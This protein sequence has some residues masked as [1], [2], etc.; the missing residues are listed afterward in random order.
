MNRS[1]VNS[2][3]TF[4]EK[5]PTTS[6]SGNSARNR[7]SPARLR[8]STTSGRQPRS[9]CRWPSSPGFRTRS[10]ARPTG[11]AC[12]PGAGDGV[13]VAAEV[14][15]VAIDQS[16]AGTP[17]RRRAVRACG[18]G[19]RDLASRERQRPESA[20][21]SRTPVAARSR[22]ANR[23]GLP[24]W[25]LRSHQLRDQLAAAGRSA[26]SAAPSR[27]RSTSSSTP[28]SSNGVS[29][30]R[31][32]CSRT[33]VGRQR[34][35]PRRFERA[36]PRR[37]RLRPASSAPSP[38]TV[39]RRPRGRVTVTARGARPAR[40]RRTCVRAAAARPGRRSSR[41]SRPTGTPETS[42]SRAKVSSTRRR[43][44]SAA[45][46][47]FDSVHPPAGFLAP[48]V[49][50][51][52]NTTPSPGRTS[53]SSAPVRPARRAASAARPCQRAR[54]GSSGTGPAPASD[55]STPSRKPCV[56]PREKHCSRSRRPCGVSVER[57]R[58]G[59][60]DGGAVGLR[61]RG[62]VWAA[63]EP[64]LDL[65]ADH[66]RLRQ[67]LDE[68]VGRQV[69]RAEQVRPVAEVARPR[70]R[71]PSRR[72]AGTPGHTGRGWR[73]GRRAPR[74]SGTG[75]CR[76]RTAPRGRTP[77]PA[78]P[79]RAATFSN[80]GGRQLAGQD[81]PLDAEFPT[82]ELDA[83]RLGQRHLRRGVDRQRRHQPIREPG[84]ARGP[85]R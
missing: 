70:R 45:I 73:C 25:P 56:S 68:V 79:S 61:R 36:R 3:A 85:A 24:R 26:R 2:L 83:A 17:G 11:D 42:R 60:V 49:C 65:E 4:R 6:M 39:R 22:L 21:E 67:R 8:T 69:L 29:P 38:P 59:G 37:G 46:R 31:P 81:H 51:Q 19:R 82:G 35:L 57:A 78:P 47:T 62:D 16:R 34:M 66:A 52:S 32:N 23:V 71:R 28:A 43:R 44:R 1:A 74:S 40:R 41:R 7:S 63:L 58:I 9:R 27:R 12:G 20:V 10:V 18:R 72:A 50:R 54:R 33:R 53:S 76:R 48:P 13:V 64:A 5:S 75:R 15:E 14:L 84:Q 55:G 77:R 80:V 30:S